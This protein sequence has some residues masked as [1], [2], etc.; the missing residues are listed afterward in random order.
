V[1]PRAIALL[2]VVPIL[3]LLGDCVGVVGGLLVGVLDLNVSPQGYFNQTLVAVHGWDVSTG[4]IKSVAFA[5]SIAL[6]ACQNGLS[7][8]GGAEEVGRR[9]T[10]SVVTTLFVLVALDA[11][12]TVIFRVFDL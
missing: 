4:L 7:A 9:T 5:L 8:S 12:F 1:V 11:T 3:T 2:L 6:I 10:V